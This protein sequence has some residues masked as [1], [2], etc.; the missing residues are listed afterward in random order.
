M[1]IL[2]YEAHITVA[3]IIWIVE[4]LCTSFH[5]FDTLRRKY[6]C[7]M[8]FFFFFFWNFLDLRLANTYKDKVEGLCG[9]FDGRSRN[10]FASPNGVLQKNVN[11]FGESWKVPLN[12][13]TSRLRYLIFYS[14]PMASTATG[15]QWTKPYL[16]SRTNCAVWISVISSS[17]GLC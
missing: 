17:L 15:S 13:K 2:M 10:D 12:R 5:L 9:D 4:V 16:K 6:F 11:I 8:A 14:I 3:T 1:F 7:V